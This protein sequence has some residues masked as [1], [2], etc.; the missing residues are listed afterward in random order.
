MRR[1]LPLLT[2]AIAAAG[3]TLA[4]AAL[5]AAA[6]SAGSPPAQGDAANVK[7][8]KFQDWESKCDPK[9]HCIAGTEGNGAA[10][11][12]GRSAKDNTLRVIMRIDPKATEGG[13][14][15]L[16]LSNGWQ[17]PLKVTKCFPNWCEILIDPTKAQD[18]VDKLKPAHEGQ[19]AYMINGEIV[20][21][22]FSLLGFSRAIGKV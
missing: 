6:Q 13:P 4:S 22:D 21:G 1:L 15:S 17:A 12:I 18:L 8:E 14:A 2:V 19:L 3:V 10:V 5:P 9:G 20:I 7:T 11:I 16:R